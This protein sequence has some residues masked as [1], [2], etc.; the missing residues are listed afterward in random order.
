MNSWKKVVTIVLALCMLIVLVGC[1]E[2][3]TSETPQDAS[4]S[5]FKIGYVANTHDS[6]MLTMATGAEDAAKELG[7]TFIPMTQSGSSGNINEQ[8]SAVEN[9]IAQD[10]DAI[11]LSANQPEAMVK[12]LTAADEA[13][14]IVVSCNVSCA[15]VFPK[16]ATFVGLEDKTACYLGGKALL[17][18]M[19]DGGKG[20][21]IGIVCGEEGQNSAI[22]RYEGYKQACE[23]A[24]ATVLAYQWTDWTAE[25]T[26]S[27]AEDWITKFGDELNGIMVPSDSMCGGL[28]PILEQNKLTGELFI[29]GMGGFQ[30]AYDAFEKGQMQA[31]QGMKPYEFGNL[32][33][34]AAYDLLNGKEVEK[35]I[36]TGVTILT[37]ENYKTADHKWID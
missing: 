2:S 23:E 37:P 33:V 12:S 5:E 29:C 16:Q 15:D 4:P 36:D 27:I 30:I 32:A 25:T 1:S 14:I 3:Q 18:Q 34:K 9:L 20:A 26:A 6:F 11:V 22:A 28:F 31:T 8:A 19:P 24:G 7:V 21:G 13:G 35:F 10:V 17:E